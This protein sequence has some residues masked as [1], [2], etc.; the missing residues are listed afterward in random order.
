MQ[1]N[2]FQVVLTS[3]GTATY[4]MFLYQEIQWGDFGTSVG[5]NAG[6]GIRG[7]NHPES[8]TTAG[9][10]NIET[11]S[12]VGPEFPGVYFYRVVDKV[13]LQPGEGMDGA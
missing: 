1:A 11:S 13:I 2:T 6:D 9:I 8:S 3:D 12:N 4:V 7:F 5:F 10:L